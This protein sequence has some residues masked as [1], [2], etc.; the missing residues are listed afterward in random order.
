MLHFLKIVDGEDQSSYLHSWK[1][2]GVAMSIENIASY[3]TNPVNRYLALP[4]VAV[5]G[6]SD[7]LS[8][9]STGTMKGKKYAPSP[10]LSFLAG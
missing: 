9:A 6:V 3:S 1:S 7:H 8:C 4:F 5:K 2:D 10:E